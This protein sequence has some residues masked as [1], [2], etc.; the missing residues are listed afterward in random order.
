[1][2]WSETMADYKKI[3]ADKFK[4]AEELMDKNDPNNEEYF[5]LLEEARAKHK[6][7]K[8]TVITHVF[9]K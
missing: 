1:M 2:I 7:K 8:K 9:K 3:I 5:K 6:A 4:K